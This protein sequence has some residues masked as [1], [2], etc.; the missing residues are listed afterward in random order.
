MGLTSVYTIDN[1]CYETK[2]HWV[3]YGNPGSLV[4]FF[5][6]PTPQNQNPTLPYPKPKYRS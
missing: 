4:I 5:I 1:A 6:S 2:L 3:P